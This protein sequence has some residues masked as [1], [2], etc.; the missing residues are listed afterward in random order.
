MPKNTPYEYSKE[1]GSP[2]AAIVTHS[3]Y[4]ALKASTNRSIWLP[5]SAVR[6]SEVRRATS[7]EII[8]FQL[9]NKE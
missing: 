8:S 2:F 3:I 7:D 5:Q 4:C 9:S 6:E 1:S